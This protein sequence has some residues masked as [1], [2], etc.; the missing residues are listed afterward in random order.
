MRVEVPVGLL[1]VEAQPTTKTAT[2]RAKQSNQILFMT[3]TDVATAHDIR[4]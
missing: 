2:I 4:A 1:A 3:G